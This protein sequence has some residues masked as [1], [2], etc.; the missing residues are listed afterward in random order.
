V[1]FDGRF[2]KRYLFPFENLY[3]SVKRE[4][5]HE[6]AYTDMGQQ[7]D[8]GITLGNRQGRKVGHHHAT[9]SFRSRNGI[10]RTNNGAHIHLCLL[11][12]QYF[13]NNFAD[14]NRAFRY[15]FR[16][17]YFLNTFKMFG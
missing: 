15:R 4:M 6:F 13:R 3:L 16:L 17:N 1:F 10:F 14:F 2:G 11:I 7:A 12:L 9:G 8:S 5:I